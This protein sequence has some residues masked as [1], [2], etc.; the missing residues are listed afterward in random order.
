MEFHAAF[1]EFR[2]KAEK[3]FATKKKEGAAKEK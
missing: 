3:I 1:E 2:N